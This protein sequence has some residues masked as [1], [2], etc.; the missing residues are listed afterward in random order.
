MP[1]VVKLLS[2]K[3]ALLFARMIESD[4]QEFTQRMRYVLDP[5]MSFYREYGLKPVENFTLVF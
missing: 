1:E 5:G 4:N 2:L 3:M